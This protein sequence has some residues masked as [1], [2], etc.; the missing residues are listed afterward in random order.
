MRVTLIHNPQAGRGH[1]GAPGRAALEQLIRGHG[2]ALRYQSTAEPD[3][4]RALDADT[5]LVAVAGGDGTVGR[6]ARALV[7]RGVPFTVLPTGTAN[8]VSKTLGLTLGLGESPWARLVAGWPGGRLVAFDVGL[9][10]GPW[11]E[12]RFIE[13]CGAGLLA[14][15]IPDADRNAT[16]TSLADG[17]ARVAYGQQMLRDRLRDCPPLTL[18]VSLDGC[19]LSGEYL[20]LEAMNMQYIGPNLYLA[21]Q[22]DLHDG[23]LD[24]LLVPP[25]DRDKL[26]GY[27]RSW[28]SGTPWPAQ[29]LSFRGRELELRW[30]GFP[31]HLDDRVW[32]APGEHAPAPPCP[33]RLSV[34]SGAL[35]FL[36]PVPHAA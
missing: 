14:C 11:G 23:M 9:A 25:A 22:C 33:V 12:A 36:L 35:Q 18:S 16:L 30:T 17:Q 8:N 1:C 27:L 4:K 24:V 28:Q 10:C 13:G 19:D 3:W 29:L 2:H 31:L 5:D 6:V 34:L 7:G 21:P 26:D 15:T 20:L 32:P